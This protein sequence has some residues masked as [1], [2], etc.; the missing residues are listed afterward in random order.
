[1]SISKRQDA[2]HEMVTSVKLVWIR[3]VDEQP[4]RAMAPMALGVCRTMD[5]TL[6]CAAIA[7]AAVKSWGLLA[8]ASFR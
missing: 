6:D 3:N 2:M 4:I 8:D 5:G 1:M 7:I